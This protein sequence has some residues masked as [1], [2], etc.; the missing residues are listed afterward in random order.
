MI[1]SRMHV[2]ALRQRT[3]H[4]FIITHRSIQLRIAASPVN[5][6]DDLRLGA[7]VTNRRRPGDGIASYNSI[8]VTN[9]VIYFMYEFRIPHGIFHVCY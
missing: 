1:L 2:S 6:V 7:L 8:Y 9:Y 4:S 3:R 5:G